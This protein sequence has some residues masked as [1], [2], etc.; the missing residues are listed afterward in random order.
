MHFDYYSQQDIE[1][2]KAELEHR[3]REMSPQQQQKD[4]KAIESKEENEEK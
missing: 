3:A 2:F 4:A 1:N